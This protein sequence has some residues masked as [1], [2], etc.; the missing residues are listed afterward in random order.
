MMSKNAEK[1]VNLYRN[2]HNCAQAVA[3]AFAQTYNMD[4]DQLYQLCEGFGGGIA[5]YEGI[6]G[7]ASGMIMITG[8]AYSNPNIVGQSKKET[9]KKVKELQNLFHERMGYIDC[10][11]LKANLDQA[12]VHG[13]P[14]GCTNC[15]KCAA[16]IVEDE[17]VGK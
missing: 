9:Y 7:A 3:C 13:K 5:G 2:G 14:I 1:A 17:I 4:E 11:E 16:Q 8:L 10:D 12:R 6:C 15:V